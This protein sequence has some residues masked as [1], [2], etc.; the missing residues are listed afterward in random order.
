MFTKWNIVHTHL[1]SAVNQL[2]SLWWLQIIHRWKLGIFSS[3]WRTIVPKESWF[4]C[5]MW[6]PN[7]KIPLW[8]SRVRFKISSDLKFAKFES[9]KGGIVLLWQLK[10]SNNKMRDPQRIL[11]KLQNQFEAFAK[12]LMG[13]L[14]GIDVSVEER[15]STKC[16][17][18]LT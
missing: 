18:I 6:L 16:H 4:N 17:K 7:I 14:N 12:I 1:V 15:F 11:P 8:F 5:R 13:H 3:I 2:M 9:M 10:R